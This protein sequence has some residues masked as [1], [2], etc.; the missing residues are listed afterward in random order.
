MRVNHH[1][2]LVKR[3]FALGVINGALF[4][5]AN[6][7]LQPTAV[8]P[9]FVLA[10]MGGGKIWVAVIASLMTSGWFWPQVFLGRYFSTRQRLLPFYWVSAAARV[11]TVVALV[12][13][14]A[15]APE[16]AHAWVFALVAG[17]FFVYASCGAI[18]MIPFMMIITDSM[19]ADWRGRFFGMRWLVGGS[20]AIAAGF[21]VKQVLAQQ[22][23]PFP[24][25]YVRLF[26]IAAV[27]LTGSVIAFSLVKEPLRAPQKH[28][29]SMGMELQ[30]GR[31]LLRRDRDWRT[32][33]WSRIFGQ[34]ASGFSLPFLVPFALEGLKA[35]EQVCGVFLAIMATASAGSNV[36]WSYLGDKRGNRKLLIW[37]SV[38]GV[39]PATIALLSLVVPATPLGSWSGIQV[40][41]RLA[42]FSLAFVP[43]G[44]ATTGQQMGQTNF[45]LDIAPDRRRPTYLGFSYLVMF[46][47]SWA[48]VAGALVIG[49][50]RFALSFAIATVAA[51]ATVLT[52]TRLREPR[53]DDL[54]LNGNSNGSEADNRPL[55]AGGQ[56]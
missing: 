31:R 35:P 21:V 50:A 16:G 28:R 42:V 18:G 12:T 15:L 32:L 45:L 49:E 22:D 51:A 7:F 11:A 13:V 2:A 30:R 6:G 41:L 33:I 25:N 5:A 44:F 1:H 8:L 29:L 27:I 37:S 3:T 52:V 4:Q 20:L 9:A 24:H 40:S 48:P 26:G 38:M 39:L 56:G 14:V 36:V 54:G 46:P 34:I 43:L 23:L 47:L 53:A 19:P 55:A 10:L 17:L